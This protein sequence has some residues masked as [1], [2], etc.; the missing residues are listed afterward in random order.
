MRIA[1]G[2]QIDARGG[3]T[4]IEA[5]LGVEALGNIQVWHAEGEML[6][7]MHRGD[8]VAARSFVGRHV[9]RCLLVPSRPVQ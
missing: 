8:T 7:R 1:E 9:H 2:V 3:V 6:Q 4:D 5:E